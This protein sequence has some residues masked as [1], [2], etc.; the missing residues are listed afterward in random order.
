MKKFSDKEMESLIPG[1][2]DPKKQP[3]ILSAMKQFAK[4]SGFD[5]NEIKNI[6]DRRIFVAV[7][8]AMMY[9][10][11]VKKMPG[12]Q[13]YEKSQGGHITGPGTG[14][15]DSIPARLSDGEY[16]IPAAVVKALGKEFFDKLLAVYK[17]KK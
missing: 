1:F 14:T 13:P 15:S 6:R 11:M 12:K 10:Q 16:V 3:H 9:D 5:E 4:M 8:K 2:T 7:H 17:G